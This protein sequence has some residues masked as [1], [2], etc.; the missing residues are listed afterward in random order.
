MKYLRYLIVAICCCPLTLFAQDI[1]GLWKGTMYNDSTKQYYE[2]EIVISKE[3]GRYSGFSHTWFVINDKKYY[4]VKKVKVNIAKNGKVIIVD[5]QL[6]GNNYPVIPN[7]YVRQL[8]VLDLAAQ[9]AEVVLNGSFVTNA[10]KDY[11]EFSGQV[12]VKRESQYSQSDLMDF[13]QKANRNN[14][15]TV[16]K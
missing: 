14:D 4:G 5:D 15:L 6:I 11:R 1:T 3:K 13:L 12:N 2:Y 7:K 10:T 9:G 8:N 16:V